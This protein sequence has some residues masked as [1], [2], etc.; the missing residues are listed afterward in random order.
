MGKLSKSIKCVCVHVHMHVY[1]AQETINI[2]EIQRN[3]GVGWSS[4]DKDW[5]DA[6]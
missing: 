4:H 6:K 2:L 1:S 3:F 5:N